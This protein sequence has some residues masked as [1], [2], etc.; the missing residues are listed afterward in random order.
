MNRSKKFLINEFESGRLL[1]KRTNAP[2]C[3]LKESSC[4]SIE[5][6]YLKAREVLKKAGEPADKPLSYEIARA[7]A[8]GFLQ[9]D[10]KI[11]DDGQ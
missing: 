6:T 4:N 3:D 9:P 8:E 5:A 11:K 1:R 2:L 10:Y 7:I